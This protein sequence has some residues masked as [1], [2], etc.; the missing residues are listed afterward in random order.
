M[1]DI[2]AVFAN[3]RKQSEKKLARQQDKINMEVQR[4]RTSKTGTTI[5]G[6]ASERAHSQVKEEFLNKETADFVARTIQRDI[7]QRLQKIREKNV[8]T[9]ENI[10]EE[11]EPFWKLDKS[12]ISR[13]ENGKRAVSFTY[14]IWFAQRFDVDLHWLLTGEKSEPVSKIL[15][16]ARKKNEELARILQKG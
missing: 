14:L 16:E 8:L 15:E 6:E 2:K 11:L 3:A 13:W 9:L 4:R 5:C 7:G 12:A 1:I 10:T